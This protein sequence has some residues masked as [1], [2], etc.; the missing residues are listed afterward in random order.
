MTEKKQPGL[1]GCYRERSHLN[2]LHPS[3]GGYK[4]YMQIIQGEQR[5]QMQVVV[6]KLMPMKIVLLKAH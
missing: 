6:H 2:Y 5:T 3:T 1:T 4:F